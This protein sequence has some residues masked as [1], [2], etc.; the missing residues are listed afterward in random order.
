[1]SV[2]EQGCLGA[3]VEVEARRESESRSEE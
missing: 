2:P 3:G 1:M